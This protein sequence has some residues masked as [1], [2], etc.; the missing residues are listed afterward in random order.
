[1]KRLTIFLPDDLAEALG[2]E[3]RRRRASVAVAELTREAL[4]EHRVLQPGRPSPLPFAAVGRG[5]AGSTARE[6]EQ[7]LE[8]EWDE[9]DPGGR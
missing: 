4:Q 6:M 9:Y 3:A 1:M 5:G 7:L 2:R 8:R